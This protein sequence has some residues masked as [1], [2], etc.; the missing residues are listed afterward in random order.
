[1]VAVEADAAWADRLRARL[2]SLGLGDRV[3]VV[4]GD[5]STVALPAEPYRVVANPPFNLTTALLHRLLDDPRTGPERLDV[6]VQWA[7]ARKRAMQPPTTLVSTAW[8]PWWEVELQRRIPRQ[9]FRP[10]PAVDAGWLTVTKR[11]PPL[12]PAELATD[13]AG[14]LRGRWSTVMST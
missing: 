8:A 3:S 10:V 13:F 2:A 4:V 6:V 1:M 5:L 14:Y 11:S 7:V 12:L 9:A